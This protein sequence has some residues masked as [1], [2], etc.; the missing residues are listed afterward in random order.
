[1]VEGAK[2]QIQPQRKACSTWSQSS[3]VE[4]GE[5]GDERLFAADGGEKQRGLEVVEAVVGQNGKFLVDF[6]RCWNLLQQQ[7]V[8]NEREDLNL[9]LEKKSEKEKQ[10]A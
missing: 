3:V 7:M 9:D 5:V 1:M 8:L 6:L 2:K 4:A 10:F